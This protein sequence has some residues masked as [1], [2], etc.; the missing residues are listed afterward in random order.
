MSLESL[1]LNALN[2]KASVNLA[3]EEFY[4]YSS[5]FLS[6]I[7]PDNT[8]PR[9]MPSVTISDTHAYQVT[10]RQ[11]TKQ[12][13]VNIYDGKDKVLIGKSCII[14]CFKYGSLQW[15]KANHTI[16][17]IIE[18]AENVAVSEVIQVPT[19]YPVEDGYYKILTGHR[20]FFAMIYNDGIE[21]AAHFKVY[22]SKPLL[23]KTKQFQ[24]NASREE[25]PQYGKLKAF[26]DAIEEVD[27]LN[28]S[29]KRLGQKP[30]TVKEVASLFGISMGAYDNYNVL[31]R[32]PAVIRAFEN[33]YT[34]PLVS[35]K[36]LILKTEKAY[37]I[38]H[39]ISML[40]V[41]HRGEINDL[42][43]LYFDANDNSVSLNDL[44]KVPKDTKS[45]AYKIGHI[46][47]AYVIETLLTKNVCDIEC[48]IDWKSVDWKNFDELNDAMKLLIEHLSKTEAR[49]TQN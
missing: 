40:N 37:K 17:S 9:F 38:K 31:T 23:L 1:L 45:K 30:L 42:L 14:N 35:V 11:L 2:E 47:S 21:G 7:L 26:Q 13:L 5:V 36:K 22:N 25:L 24:E 44:T 4:D 29:K 8:N 27:I 10:T 6:K 48:G 39:G 41:Y 18:L 46:Q 20:R 34:E 16:K 49:K 32:Y 3:K 33:G 19:I 12:Q 15:K 28:N 43:C